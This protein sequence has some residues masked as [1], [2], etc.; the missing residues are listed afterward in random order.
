MI[1]SYWEWTDYENRPREIVLSF[2]LRYAMHKTSQTHLL[3][4]IKMLTGKKKIWLSV[5]KDTNVSP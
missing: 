4:M 3:S 1:K 5:Q 2:K